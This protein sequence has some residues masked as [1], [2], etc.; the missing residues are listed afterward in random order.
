MLLRVTPTMRHRALEFAVLQL[1]M[2]VGPAGYTPSHMVQGVWDRL[3][4]RRRAFARR[5]AA[6]Q[7]VAEN[8]APGT[9]MLNEEYLRLMRIAEAFEFDD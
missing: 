6:A 4:E 5:L 2:E 9:P 7:S 8:R 3:D 1:D